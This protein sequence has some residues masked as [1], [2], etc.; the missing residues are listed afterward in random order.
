M[1][2]K[3][4]P[5]PANNKAPVKKVPTATKKAVVTKKMASHPT[6]RRSASDVTNF[7][8]IT[9]KKKEK[10]PF[11]W[12]TVLAAVCF[13]VL[14]LF[15]MLNY[16]ALDEL[17]DEVVRQDKVIAE[18]SDKKDK[19]EDSVTKK[20][21][22]DEITKYAEN[23]LGMVKKEEVEGQYYIDLNTDDE[24]NITEY[25]DETENGLG[26]LLTGVGNVIKDFIGG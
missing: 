19:L 18:L 8:I 7:K 4:V 9:E 17:K 21:N 11:P 1:E 5:T 20:D 6:A 12:T 13:T 16:T 23:E 25:E 26:V 22:L 14:F 3:R 15:M 10:K 2:Q 24:V